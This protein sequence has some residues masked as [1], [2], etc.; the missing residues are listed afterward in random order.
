MVRPRSLPLVVFSLFFSLPALGAIHVWT[1][2]GDDRFSNSS[3]WIGGSPASDASAEISFPASSRPTATNDLNGLTLQSIAFSADG[4]AIGGNALTLA[5]GATV[6]DTSKG[7]NTISCNLVLAGDVAVVVAGNIYGPESLTLSG[8]ISGGGGVTLR[9]GGILIYAGSQPNAY[10]GVTRV[11]F[12]ELQLKKPANVTAIAADVDVEDDGNNYEYGYLGIF[13]DEQIAKT[14]HLTVGGLSTFVCGATQTLGPVTLTRGAALWTGTQLSGEIPLTGTIILAGDIEITGARQADISSSGTFLLQGIRTINASAGFG[15]WSLSG[16]GQE[17]AGSGIILTGATDANGY[18]YG[19]LQLRQATYD[20][21]TTIKGGSVMIDAPRSAVDLQAGRYSGHCKSLTAE[22]GAISLH[23]YLGGVTSDGDVKLSSAVTV[24]HDVGTALKMNGTL[25]LGGATLEID[26]TSSYSYGAVY[27]VVDN[28]STTPVIGTFANLPEGSMVANRYRISYEGGDGND[29]TLTDFGLVPST[30]FLTLS[31]D[32]PQAGTPIDFSATVSTSAQTVTGTITFSAG[33]TVLGIVPVNN[34]RAATFTGSL[35]RGQYKVTAAYSGD[36][37]VAPST[38]T[39]NLSV[40][41]VAPTLTSIDPSPLTGGVRVTLTLH[42]T[43][44][45]DGSYVL[46]Q[47]NGYAATFVSSTELQLD[48]TPFAYQTDYQLDVSVV[49]PDPYG[50]RSS[51]HLM[52]SVTGVPRPPSPPSPFTFGSDNTITLTGVTPGAMTFWLVEATIGN[53]SYELYNVVTDTNH[54]GSVSLPFPFQVTALPPTGVWAVA[55]LSAHTIASDNPTHN[56]PAKSPFPAK[57]F[58]RDAGGNYTHVQFTAKTYGS[59]LTLA[60][61]RAGLG[62]WQV[63]LADGGAPDED[64]GPND[65]LTFETSSMLRTIGTTDP[66]PA[67]GIQPGDMFMV[68]DVFGSFWWGDAVDS[69]LSESDGAGRLGFAVQSM[70]AAEGSG[71]ANVLVERTEGTDGTVT[72]QFATAD[73]TAIAGRNY[74]AQ[75]GTLTFGPGEIFRTIA[76]PL[77]DDHAYD[78]NAQFKV[79]LSNPAGASMS[80]FTTETVVI[81]D[82]EPPPVLSIVTPFSSVPEGDAGEVDIPITVKLTGSTTLPVTVSWSWSEGQYGPFHNGQLQFAPGETQKTFTVSYIANT[83][84]EP[85]RILSMNLGNPKNATASTDATKITIVDDDF[86]GVSV[87]DASV[88]ENA[89]KVVVPLELS[90][91]TLKPVTVTY[92]TRNATAFAGSN[93]VATSGTMT[94][95][96]GASITIPILDDALPGPIRAFEVVLT[97]VSGGKLE[98]STAAVIIVDNDAPPPPAPPRR[99]SVHH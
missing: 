32:Y 89:G 14:A 21:P 60:W 52:L 63:S 72:V 71:S 38:A 47:S 65:R 88:L 85:D 51:G 7:V 22:G 74:V 61:A 46:I 13:N 96:S 69:H 25:D 67:G 12:G 10:T 33:A 16:P 82:S 87:A 57:A 98:R 84:P 58:L 29:V 18:A 78:G 43:N 40:V 90:R 3:N 83:T 62:A 28:T 19:V 34:N 73:D 99:R 80:A 68:V 54:D 50:A 70:Y 81:R 6:I 15:Q 97:S 9:G 26:Q 55:D 5:P 64:G 37:R 94:I 75:S 92:E 41:A 39:G 95:T 91:S 53:H 86:A 79:N 1:G 23:S 30:V 44:F 2:A 48:Y 24:A 76:V 31:P 77:I 93:Y 36:S 49:Q 56:A 59:L 11:L 4:F 17:T 42:G 35:P 66:P 8:A 20:G 27:K 45:V